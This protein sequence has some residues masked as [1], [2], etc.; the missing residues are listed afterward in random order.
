M[1]ELALI[2]LLGATV[3]SAVGF[4]YSLITLPLFLQAGLNLPQAVAMSF[5]TSTVQRVFFVAKRHSA[6]DW[7]K[8]WV[9]IV[10]SLLALPV[11]VFLLVLVSNESMSAVKQLVGA[12]VLLTVIL[13]L[14]IRIKPKSSIGMI[15]GVLA[16]ISS[17]VLSGLANVGGPPIILWIYAHEWRKELLHSAS[18]AISM[19]LIPVQAGLLV[20]KF[21]NKVLPTML[22]G[23]CFAPLALLGIFIGLRISAKVDV[24]VLR[25]VVMALL[26]VIGLLYVI[27]PYI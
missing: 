14:S 26:I 22:T 10:F 25:G 2:V 1:I 13:R 23:L 21:G 11:G 15:W 5:A 19:P 9:P 4:A 3:Q 20:W 12:L 17:G 18:I 6:I 27:H 7:G 24:K 8:L 16:G